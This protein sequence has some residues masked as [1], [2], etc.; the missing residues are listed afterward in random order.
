VKV[1]LYADYSD[2]SL[3]GPRGLLGENALPLSDATKLRIKA[4]FNAY[5]KPRP[6]WPLWSPPDELAGSDAEE[7]AWVEEGQAIR[8]LIAAELG[9]TYEVTFET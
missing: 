2:W 5:S 8:D 3:W 6:D 1:V 7:D 4:W 9:P